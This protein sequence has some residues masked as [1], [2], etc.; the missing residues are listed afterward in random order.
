[1]WRL[2]QTGIWQTNHR[3]ITPTISAQT[4]E[5]EK[6]GATSAPGWG[7]VRRQPYA[8]FEMGGRRFLG[9]QTVMSGKTRF[10]RTVY[11]AILGL[12]RLNFLSVI[13]QAGNFVW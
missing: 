1:M 2:S 3:P 10:F 13:R 11:G 12:M 6:A 7:C 9:I 5:P 8:W 4:G